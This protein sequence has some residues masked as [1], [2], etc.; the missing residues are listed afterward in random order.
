MSP[1]ETSADG[2]AFRTSAGFAKLPGAKWSIKK[3]RG[4]VPVSPSRLSLALAFWAVL[5]PGH[6][7][8]QGIFHVPIRTAVQPEAVLTGAGAVFWNLGSM[9]GG[10]GTPQEMVLIHVVGPSSSGLRGVAG[11]GVMALPLGFRAGLGYWH[12]GIQDIPRTS[13]SPAPELGE[14]HV[15]E[16]VGVLGLARDLGRRS[17]VG[18]GL[19]LAQGSVGRDTR[20]SVEGELGVHLQPG[21]PLNPVVG[22]AIHGLGTEPVAMGG[23]ELSLPPLASSRLPLR[24][25][26]GFRTGLGFDPPEHRAS[27]RASWEERIHAG[28]GMAFLGEGGGW[29]LLAALGADL[30]RYSFSVLREGMANG[31]GAIHFYRVAIRFP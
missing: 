27:F 11:A 7:R 1:L 25:G 30:G 6:A 10:P 26:Y 14:V 21:L 2:F 20:T 18:A 16:D 19:R 29:V 12:L 17:G 5:L 3:T 15:A 31:F 13:T 4:P 8:A 22:L 24:A 28:A 9:V 23:L